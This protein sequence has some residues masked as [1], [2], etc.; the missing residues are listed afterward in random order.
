MYTCV[1]P[2]SNETGEVHVTVLGEQL[3]VLKSSGI[4]MNN[5]YY[6]L[7]FIS[8]AWLFISAIVHPMFSRSPIFAQ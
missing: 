2:G 1:I 5:S 3:A 6:S 4:V 8:C 7:F